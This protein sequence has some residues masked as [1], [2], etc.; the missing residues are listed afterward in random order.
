VEGSDKLSSALGRLLKWS[1]RVQKSLRRETDFALDKSAD[2]TV[3][4]IAD[5]L[6]VV[7]LCVR[8]EVIVESTDK[9]PV[10]HG[11]GE[12]SDEY[13]GIVRKFWEISASLVSQ[14]G[15]GGR[16]GRQLCLGNGRGRGDERVEAGAP[17]S[18][19][20]IDQLF[21]HTVLSSVDVDGGGR[22][23]SEEDIQIFLLF[24]QSFS[25][26]G[27]KSNML[28]PSLIKWGKKLARVR[29]YPIQS[30]HVRRRVRRRRRRWRLRLRWPGVRPDNPPLG[31][32]VA[33]SPLVS[34]RRP[35]FV[36]RTRS[37]PIHQIDRFQKRMRGTTSWPG[38]TRRASKP[39]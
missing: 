35:L 2:A 36:T 12:A 31:I 23:E 34:Q 28:A 5:D 33:D 20:G 27:S 15:C 14:L 29:Q 17:T 32:D 39:V 25:G 13:A 18:G 6:D 3:A 22:W 38:T 7:N 37:L 1:E 4:R 30:D 9:L 16:R 8:S 21:R 24:L 10:V 26:F 19:T 11:R